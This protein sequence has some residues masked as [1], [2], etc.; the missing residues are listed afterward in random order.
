[1][2]VELIG[3]DRLPMSAEQGPSRLC[4]QGPARK[5]AKN[6]ERLGRLHCRKPTG[7]GGIGDGSL[8][9]SVATA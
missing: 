9:S 6:D 3:N 2:M 8:K 5:T 4:A 1:M 7:T